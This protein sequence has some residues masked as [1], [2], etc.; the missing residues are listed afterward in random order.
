MIKFLILFIILSTS[1][2]SVSACDVPPYDQAKMRALFPQG[3]FPMS[4]SSTAEGRE[5]HF[6]ST[7]KDSKSTRP[8]IAFVHGAPGDWSAFAAYLAD[9][10]LRAK[11]DMISVDRL[12][13]G[14]SEKGKW[15]ESLPRQARLLQEAVAQYPKADPVILVGHSF[16]GPVLARYGI[17]Y[18]QNADHLIML[19]ASV[20]P[21]LEKTKWF[22][23]IADWW[24]VEW[25]VPSPLNVANQEILPLKSELADMSPLWDKITAETVVIQGQDDVLVPPGNAAFIAEKLPKAQII[26]LDNQG[27]FLPWEQYDLVKSTIL[28]SI[29]NTKK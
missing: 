14:L 17:D 10:D 23:I 21:D 27:H 26:Y 28:K 3:E 1:L 4:Q 9:E 6:V 7:A 19:A 15:E 2:L 24:W 16:G 29:A 8:L 11:A 22:Q 13:Y 20:D 18:P 25:L 5:M 12:G